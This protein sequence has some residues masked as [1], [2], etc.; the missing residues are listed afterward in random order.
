MFHI[1]VS[2]LTETFSVY[3]CFSLFRFCFVC[4]FFTEL[5]VCMHNMIYYIIL[6]IVLNNTFLGH[7]NTHMAW[8]AAA[9]CNTITILTIIT[10]IY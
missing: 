2:L 7:D 4:V 8:T 10:P 5:Q 6:Y 3:F 1:C 9:L